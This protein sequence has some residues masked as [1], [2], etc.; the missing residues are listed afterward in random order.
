MPVAL[1]TGASRGVGG[2]AAL[3]L[4]EAGFDVALSAR[5]LDEGELRDHSPTIA[6]TDTR[7]LS[8][9]LQQT[10]TAITKLGRR[11]LVVPADL[12]DR[13][14]LKST[15]ST[16][17]AKWG[18]ID[19]LVLAGSYVGP[20]VAD[21]VVDTSLETLNA[22]MEANV[23]APL[24][25]IKA[26]LPQMLERHGGTIVLITSPVATTE[27]IDATS[28]SDVGLG[29]VMSR[30]AAQRIAPVLATELSGTGIRVCN[31]L[32]CPTA[33]ERVVLAAADAGRDTSDL[34][35][36]EVVGR[37]VAWIC[38]NALADRLNGR[39]V[40]AALVCEELGLVPGWPLVRA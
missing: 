17:L 7:P 29:E 10:A 15:V 34:A 33:T 16:V 4:A 12:L 36:P 9:S 31:V 3:A 21:R 39:T 6:R 19:A 38:T 37:V 13:A 35:P 28:V 32:P 27:T 18:R 25:L 5:T 26:V 14:S 2:A 11:A 40:D 30:S 24:T 20:G 22:Q 23:M 8:G 1:V